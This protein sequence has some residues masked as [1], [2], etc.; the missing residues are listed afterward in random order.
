MDVKDYKNAI[1]YYKKELEHYESNPA[2]VFIHVIYLCL[3]QNQE[4][5]F[6]FICSH[7]ARFSI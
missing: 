7:V 1:K 3:I 4:N 2:E 6:H 5:R